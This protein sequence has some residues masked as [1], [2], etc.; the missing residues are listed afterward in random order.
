M[1]KRIVVLL[2]LPTALFGQINVTFQVNMSP[3]I[4][5]GLFIPGSDS[6]AVIGNFQKDAGD[7]VNW[8]GPAFKMNPKNLS[9][10]IYSVTIPFPNDLSGMVYEYKFTKDNWGLEE[11]ASRSFILDSSA[12][13]IPVSYFN[14]DSINSEKKLVKA[15]VTFIADIRGIWGSGEGYF[16]ETADSIMIIG[17]SNERVLSG[18]RRLQLISPF[19]TGV[20]CT[21]LTLQG[22]A[23]DTAKYQYRAFPYTA[24]SDYGFENVT[25]RRF[26]FP[27]SDSTIMLPYEIPAITPV[28]LLHKDVTVCFTVTFPKNAVNSINGMAIP[29]DK[30][31]W[32]GIKGAAEQLGSWGGNWTIADTIVR[33]HHAFATLLKMNDSGVDGDEK[34]G[35]GVWSKNVL[36]PSGSEGGLIEYE[37]GCMYPGADTVN[38]G[39]D[40]L[41]NEMQYN[42]HHQ[43]MLINPPSGNTI[44]ISNTFGPINNCRCGVRDEDIHPLDAVHSRVYSLEQ[45]YPNPFNPSTKI[46]FTVPEEGIVSLK[47]YNILG[48]EVAVLANRQMKAG[49]YEVDFDG[50]ALSTG[51]YLYKLSIGSYTAMKKMMLMK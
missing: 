27:Y 13:P 15:T 26:Q 38:G 47:V 5:A 23:G 49:S 45:N 31:E 20:Y 10:S 14:N 7:T 34:A 25:N 29:K 50:S 35:D 41:R 46:R 43:F 17:L 40:P 44:H 11:I 51:V 16:D 36:F 4:K 2:L 21:T 8:C 18:S 28:I 9:D 24:F 3:Q 33:P 30:I 48:R 12:A 32:V 6:L 37:Y 39:S 42:M 19:S 1:M 22:R